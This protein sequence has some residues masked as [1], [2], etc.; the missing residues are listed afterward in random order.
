[1][2]TAGAASVGLAG[3]PQPEVIPRRI[4]QVLHDA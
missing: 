1:M 2:M 3:E 4:S